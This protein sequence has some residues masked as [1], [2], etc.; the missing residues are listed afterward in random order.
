MTTTKNFTVTGMSCSHCESAVRS[1]LAELNG[2]QEISVSAAAG[3]LTVTLAEGAEVPEAAIIEAVDDAGY[4][5]EP[6]S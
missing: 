1:E 5:A 6:A 3:E 4:Q 2:I